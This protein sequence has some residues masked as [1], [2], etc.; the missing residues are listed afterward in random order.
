MRVLREQY[1][2]SRSTFTRLF[3]SFL[4]SLLT[5][6]QRTQRTVFNTGSAGNYNIKVRLGQTDP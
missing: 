6:E 2:H 4:L 5:I 1:V 3:N